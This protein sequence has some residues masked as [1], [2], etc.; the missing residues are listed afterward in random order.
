MFIGRL[1]KVKTVHNS[2]KNKKRLRIMMIY[3]Y[4]ISGVKPNLMFY[5]FCVWLFMHALYFQQNNHIPSWY[6]LYL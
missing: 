6:K 4:S 3:G 1:E 2:K 5:F